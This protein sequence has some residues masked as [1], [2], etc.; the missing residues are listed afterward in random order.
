VLTVTLPA[1][2]CVLDLKEAVAREIYPS[3][4]DDKAATQKA[5]LSRLRVADIYKSR[6]FGQ[7][8]NSAPLVDIRTTDVSALLA[9]RVV[10]YVWRAPRSLWSTRWSMHRCGGV[11]RSPPCGTAT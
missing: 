1:K 7:L 5:K 3:P 9:A 11:M 2:G 4:E 8:K 10:F 6:V